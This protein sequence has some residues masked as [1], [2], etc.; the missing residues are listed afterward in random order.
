M[1]LNLL[2]VRKE[3]K[4]INKIVYK[5]TPELYRE[6]FCALN[7]CLDLIFLFLNDKFYSFFQC[8]VIRVSSRNHLKF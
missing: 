4:A 2:C 6:F 8:I 7:C 1:K 5:K 3:D